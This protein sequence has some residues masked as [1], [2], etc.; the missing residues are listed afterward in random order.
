MAVWVMG[1]GTLALWERS[2]GTDT[3]IL[4]GLVPNPGVMGPKKG[5][6]DM[7]PGALLVEK[8]SRLT[9]S[10]NKGLGNWEMRV[11]APAEF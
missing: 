8:G 9:N 2:T 1:I 6:N 10:S 4:T 11:T 3:G 7:S 5:S